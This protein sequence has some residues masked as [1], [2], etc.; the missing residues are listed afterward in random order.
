[1]TSPVTWEGL[2]LTSLLT[3]SGGQR[4]SPLSTSPPSV[5][6]T[7][8]EGRRLESL[9]KRS[10]ESGKTWNRRKA[11]IRAYSCLQVSSGLGTGGCRTV[12]SPGKPPLQKLHLLS[13]RC[14]LPRSSQPIRDRK[15]TGKKIRLMMS[16][17][18]HEAVVTLLDPTSCSDMFIQISGNEVRCSLGMLGY[19]TSPRQPMSVNPLC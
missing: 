6:S 10:T 7:T 2:S 3:S 18:A 9:G 19:V 1:M 17:P 4:S 14:S 12:H 15:L 13:H 11:P 8:I 5:G 16:L